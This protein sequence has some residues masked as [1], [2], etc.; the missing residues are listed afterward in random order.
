MTHANLKVDSTK[1]NRQDNGIISELIYTGVAQFLG[2]I[3]GPIEYAIPGGVSFFGPSTAMIEFLCD[4]KVLVPK[5]SE[6]EKE[7]QINS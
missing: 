5:D 1:L 4:L 6:E 7:V 2:T 3:Q